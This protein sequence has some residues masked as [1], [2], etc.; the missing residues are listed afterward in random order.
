MQ[1]SRDWKTTLGL[2]ASVARPYLYVTRLPVVR[3]HHSF[4]AVQRAY[5]YGYKTEIRGWFLQRDELID[6]ATQSGLILVREF[7]FA[8]HP[9]VRGAPEDAEIRG[10]LFRSTVRT[11]DQESVPGH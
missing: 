10:F 6:A 4:G 9:T 11:D 5:A 7:G 1:Y 3:N 2:L 8:R